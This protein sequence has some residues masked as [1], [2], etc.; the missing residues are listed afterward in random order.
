MHDMVRDNWLR[1]NLP[2]EGQVSFMYLDVRGWVCTGVGNKIDETAAELSPPSPGERAASLILAHQMQWTD[3]STG[4]AATLDQVA[5]DWDAVKSRLDLAAVGYLAFEPITQLRLS[6]DEILRLVD[7]KLAQMEATLLNRPEFTGF[8]GWPA[9]AQLATLS[10]CWAMGPMF[11]FPRF[12]AHVAADEWAGAAD[13]CVINPD[14]GT[15]RIRNKLDRM[16][17][18][19]AGTVAAQGLAIEQ[20]SVTLAD[21]LGVQHA[22]WMLGFHAGAQDGRDGPSTQAGVRAFQAERGLDQ[23]GAWDDVAT[24]AELGTALGDAGWLVV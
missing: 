6:E 16:H 12:Q 4:G 23:D 9:S 14:E 8:D 19:N 18:L 1:F 21:V 15:I 11:K 22:L 2:L 5:V 7:G 10:M 3:K 17:L 13:E 20:L 24:Q